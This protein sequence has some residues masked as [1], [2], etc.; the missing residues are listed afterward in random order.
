MTENLRM[1]AYYFGFGSCGAIEID[2]I[3]SAVCDA[4]KGFHNTDCWSDE[5]D[6]LGN[7]SYVD[8]IQDRANEAATVLL[9]QRDINADLLAALKGMLDH[10]ALHS[11]DRDGEAHDA[12][13]NA[14]A[15]IARAQGK[16]DE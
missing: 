9:A 13:I 5:Q 15:A 6:Y 1:N 2:R 16:T 3:L 8:L 14:Q 7:K 4:G 10:C 11:H 12:W